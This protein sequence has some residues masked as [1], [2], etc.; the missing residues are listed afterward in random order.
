VI[1]L[2]E[3]GCPQNLFPT[4]SEEDHPPHFYRTR[5]GRAPPTATPVSLSSF[6]VRKRQREKNRE[7]RLLLHKSKALEV[8]RARWWA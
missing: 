3:E 2:G 7:H 5:R 4:F 8:R 6:R 1:L